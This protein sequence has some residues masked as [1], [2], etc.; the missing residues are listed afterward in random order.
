MPLFLITTP[1]HSL[2]LSGFLV[3]FLFLS[4][5]PQVSGPCATLQLLLGATPSSIAVWS[6]THTTPSSG[7][8]MACCCQTTI[9]RWYMRMVHSSSVMCRK[10]WTRERTC[11]VCSSNPSSLSARP[12][13]SLSKVSSCSCAIPNPVQTTFWKYEELPWHHTATVYKSQTCD[14][15]TLLDTFWIKNLKEGFSV[16]TVWSTLCVCVCVFMFVHPCELLQGNTDSS[17]K[18]V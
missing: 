1:H 6:A 2:L 12:S 5:A 11:A 10:E 8:K 14:G 9:G 13:M 18:I 15:A 17:V 3:V 7:T 16:R 4:Q